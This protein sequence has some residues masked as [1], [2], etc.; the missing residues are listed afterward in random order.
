MRNHTVR[1][2]C[3]LGFWGDS[4]AAVPRLLREGVPAAFDARRRSPA[5]ALSL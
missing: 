5:F 2:G 3:A 4:S 1:I